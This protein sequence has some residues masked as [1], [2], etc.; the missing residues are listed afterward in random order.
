MRE[1]VV[2]QYGNVVYLTDERWKHILERH[3]ELDGH[4]TEILHA[5]RSAKRR[6][7]AFELDT[8]YYKKMLSRPIDGLDYLEVV[9][10]CH[11]HSGKPNNFVVTA[12]LK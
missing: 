4:R 3:S 10:I 6:R 2:D 1:E 7:D 5:V 9:V 8:F 12:Y 11:W